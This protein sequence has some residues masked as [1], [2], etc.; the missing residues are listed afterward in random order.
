MK[1]KMRNPGTSLCERVNIYA[2]GSTLHAKTITYHDVTVVCAQHT[3]S[4]ITVTKT[5]VAL[6]MHYIITQDFYFESLCC[7]RLCKC[8]LTTFVLAF[9]IKI[10]VR[11]QNANITLLG[12][13]YNGVILGT[14]LP[15]N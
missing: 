15:K 8:S 11:K 2:L 6:S 9:G 14:R 3:F 5:E 7:A 12:N 4:G 13:V 10:K 1:N